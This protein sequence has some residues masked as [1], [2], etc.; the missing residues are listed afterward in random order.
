MDVYRFG[1]TGALNETKLA[2][3]A[4]YFRQVTHLIPYTEGVDLTTLSEAQFLAAITGRNVEGFGASAGTLAFRAPSMGF[5]MDNVGSLKSVLQKAGSKIKDAVKKVGDNIKE[6]FAKLTNWIFKGPIQKAALFFTYAFV[7]E[8]PT[9][10]IAQKKAKQLRIIDFIASATGSKRE[11][12]MTTIA[13]AITQ[14]TGKT[15]ATLLNDVAGRTIA[16]Q[17]IG[18]ALAAASGAVTVIIEIVQKVKAFLKKNDAE[19]PDTSDAEPTASDFVGTSSAA[20][21]VST[22]KTTVPSSDGERV[23]IPTPTKGGET[24]PDGEEPTP[25]G[26]S[27]IKSVPKTRTAADTGGGGGN[28]TAL[29]IGG[30]LVLAALV[31][32]R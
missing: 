16:G 23:Q 18:F 32:N 4:D 31:L 27:K 13:A 20:A 24:D 14:Q 19:M 5:D 25:A 10:A 21:P 29:L 12:V 1:A 9:A 6:A 8:A 15:P 3:I 2:N 22:P 7:N 26:G 30:A 17:S 28:N 11:T